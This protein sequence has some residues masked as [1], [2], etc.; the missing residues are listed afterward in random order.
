MA[1]KREITMNDIQL[2]GIVIGV[3]VVAIFILPPLIKLLQIPGEIID[4]PGKVV[5]FLKNSAQKQPLPPAKDQKTTI[6]GMSEDTL[7]KISDQKIVVKYN[8]VPVRSAAKS[9]A[10]VIKYVNSGSSP[11]LVF[12]AANEVI[13]NKNITWLW[14]EDVPAGEPYGWIRMDDT[15]FADSISCLKCEQNINGFN[16]IVN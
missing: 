10:S 12:S 3:G 13:G 9:N 16:T 11:G 15:T 7:Q 1:K 2:W 5:D 4:A 14:I 8:N 6:P